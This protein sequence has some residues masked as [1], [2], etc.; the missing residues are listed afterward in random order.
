MRAEG[1]ASLFQCPLKHS[2]CLLQRPVRSAGLICAFV[3]RQSACLRICTRSDG[4]DVCVSLRCEVSVCVCVRCPC[5]CVEDESLDRSHSLLDVVAAVPLD[6]S[7][8]SFAVPAEGSVDARIIN[9]ASAC[10]S[11]SAAAAC[12]AAEGD[13]SCGD[14]AWTPSARASSASDAAGA[15]A[16]ASCR[17]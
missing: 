12:L 7:A 4:H 11:S 14:V 2:I 10:R 3:V 5:E 1:L 6:I 9:S 15:A 16:S 17:P 13:T 8:I